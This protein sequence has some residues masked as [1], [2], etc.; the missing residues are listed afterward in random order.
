[1]RLVVLAVIVFG[2]SACFARNRDLDVYE[3]CDTSNDC[4]PAYD[5]TR[6]RT[7]TTDGLLLD[8]RMCTRRCTS[9][10]VCPGNRVATTGACYGV[11]DDTDVNRR[12]CFARCETDYDCEPGSLCYAATG[13][14]IADAICMP[15]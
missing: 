14:G 6:V 5:C 10:T 8:G 11:Q 3:Q 1:M 7:T 15:Q 4:R 2:A 13:E 12:A 9:D